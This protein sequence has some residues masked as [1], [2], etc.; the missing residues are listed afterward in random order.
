MIHRPRRLRAT[1]AHRRLVR[2]H[3]L[4]TADLILPMFV[5]EGLEEPQPI[6]SLPGVVQ[7]DLSSLR[8]AAR[9]AA[10]LG[11]GGIMLF[12]VPEAVSYTHLTLPTILR[13]CRSRWSPY[14]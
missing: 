7:H 11:L 14:H 13:S 2:E 6:S 3:T 1:A 4:R 8:G 9:E 10:E 12:G 5:R